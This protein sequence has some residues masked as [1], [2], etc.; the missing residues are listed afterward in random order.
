MQKPLL[1]SG[2]GIGNTRYLGN[3]LD[4]K[5]S[6]ELSKTKRSLHI[7][8]VS[9]LVGNLIGFCQKEVAFEFMNLAKCCKASNESSLQK[10][11]TI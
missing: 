1:F 2:N 6:H 8:Y 7:A 4:E 3:G 9:L 5:K 11:R 10:K